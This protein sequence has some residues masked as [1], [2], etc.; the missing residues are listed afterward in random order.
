[1]KRFHVHVAVADLAAGVRFYSALFDCPPSVLKDDYAKWQLE[2]PRVNFAI[3]ARGASPGLNH[4]GIQAESDAELVELKARLDRA[5]LASRSETRVACCY[6]RSDKHWVSDPA[7][8][9]WESFHTLAA[10]P[11][12]DEPAA[13][14]CCTPSAAAPSCPAGGGHA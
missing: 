12:F 1:M 10:T 5:A 2:D 8:L 7:G 3:S 4:L 9:A 13:N 6:S 11:T 14:T